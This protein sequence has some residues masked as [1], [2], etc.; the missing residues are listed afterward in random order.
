M[1]MLARGFVLR[2]DRERE[3]F[4]GPQMQ[5]RDLLCVPLLRFKFAEIETIRA[6]HQIDRGQDQQRRLPSDVSV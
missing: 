1:Q 5:A 3:R 2:L 6:V 4:D